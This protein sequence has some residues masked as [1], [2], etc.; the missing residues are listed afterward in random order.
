MKSKQIT[1]TI[2]SKQYELASSKSEM[3]PLFLLLIYFRI[4]LTIKRDQ[5]DCPWVAARLP[6][7]KF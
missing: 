3:T 4:T 1:S 2:C 6:A 5:D 7:W